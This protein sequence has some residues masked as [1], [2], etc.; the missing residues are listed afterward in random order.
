MD[1]FSTSA[2]RG[3]MEGDAVTGLLWQAGVED[4]EDVVQGVV[5]LV[6]PTVNPGTG[7][8][9]APRVDEQREHADSGDGETE[10]DHVPH[11]TCDEAVR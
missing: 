4:D 2:A 5:D 9:E 7:A 3:R 10:H 8:R 11:S 1:E 6:E